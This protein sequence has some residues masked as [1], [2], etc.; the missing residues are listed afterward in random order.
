MVNYKE[1]TVDFKEEG[2]RIDQF[3]ARRD[4]EISRSQVQKLITGGNVTINGKPALKANFRVKAG[5]RINI[6]IPEPRKLEIRP[7]PIPLS[8]I[9]EDRDLIVV[10]KPK[11]MVVHPAA[12]HYS[13]TLVNA[14]LYHCRDLSGI[15]GV[16]RPGI[17][18]RLDKDTSGILVAAK[19]DFTHLS[20]AC[21]IKAREMKREYIAVVHGKISARDGTIDIPIGRHPVHR[22]KMAV[23]AEGKGKRA[24]THYKV[25]KY[26]GDYTLVL[27][28]LE[29]G[30]TH[31]IRV[32]MAYIGHPVVGD[33]QYGYR[34]RDKQFLKG[35][36]LHALSVGFV[37]PRRGKYVEFYAEPPEEFCEFLGDLPDLKGI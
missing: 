29:T 5:D 17:V 8:V 2:K 26:Y 10:N 33:Q 24:V 30:R 23:L 28:A 37:H 1:F 21:Q 20:L 11:G 4:L 3:L 36:L 31:Q 16:L 19:N 32:H 13:G 18:H 14:L 22:K 6:L 15:N 34:T 9:Y 35:Q 25:I 27:A 12:G 7:E